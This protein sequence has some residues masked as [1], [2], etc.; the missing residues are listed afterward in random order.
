METIGP[1]F[2]TLSVRC[3]SFNAPCPDYGKLG[4]GQQGAQLAPDRS[5]EC[6]KAPRYGSDACGCSVEKPMA[7]ERT[8]EPRYGVGGL[9]RSP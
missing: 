5:T 1:H 3:A 7:A 2:R 8:W 9:G 6:T 4:H